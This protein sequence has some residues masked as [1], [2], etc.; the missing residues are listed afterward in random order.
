MVAARRKT[1]RR[2]QET[3][4]TE[5]KD[6]VRFIYVP[7]DPKTGKVLDPD[8]KRAGRCDGARREVGSGD[9]GERSETGRGLNNEGVASVLIA[10][11]YC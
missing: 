8:A 4:R 6:R 1:I 5:F 11:G 2:L 10:A 7:C 3:V 9:S